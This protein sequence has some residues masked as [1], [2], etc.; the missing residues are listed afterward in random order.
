MINKTHIPYLLD[1]TSL[2]ISRHTSGRAE[3]NSRRSLILPV[4]NIRV[5]RAHM[6]NPH[7]LNGNIKIRYSSLAFMRHGGRSTCEIIGR[8]KKKTRKID[9]RCRVRRYHFVAKRQLIKKLEG[10]LQN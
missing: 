5:A 9:W 10:L 3:Q 8:T 4:A 6:N 2:L 1:Q 7:D